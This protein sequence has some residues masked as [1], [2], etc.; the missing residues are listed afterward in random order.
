MFL[1]GHAPSVRIDYAMGPQHA[2]ADA[3]FSAIEENIRQLR[4]EIDEAAARHASELA[5][6]RRV[7]DERFRTSDTVIA[8]VAAKLRE[9]QAGAIWQAAFA[10]S[11]IFVGLLICGFAPDIGAP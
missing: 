11:L 4:K 1:T 6:T 8:E 10:L 2:S 7:I 5:D 9:S 3:R